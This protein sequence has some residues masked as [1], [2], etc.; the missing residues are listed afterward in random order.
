MYPLSMDT[1]IEGSR[2]LDERSAKTQVKRTVLVHSTE[3][4]KLLPMISATHV[5]GNSWH[6][7]AAWRDVARMTVILRCGIHSNKQT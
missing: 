1:K 6:H 7:I 5:G 3:R 4:Q 2:Q